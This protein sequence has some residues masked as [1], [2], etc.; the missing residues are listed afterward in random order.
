MNRYQEVRKRLTFES[1]GDS[2]TLFWI[3]CQHQEFG[4]LKC[5]SQ[6]N[7]AREFIENV[8]KGRFIADR[9]FSNYVIEL[10]TEVCEKSNKPTTLP[11]IIRTLKDLAFAMNNKIS[12][13]YLEL[14]NSGFI[15]DIM[16]PTSK[17]I[18]K[19]G[20]LV[21]YKTRTGR[22]TVGRYDEDKIKKYLDSMKK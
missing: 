13:N 1:V 20:K 12:F 19:K 14:L 7:K 17:Y 22:I 4:E 15:Q 8:D 9:N 10:W 18:C 2:K 11:H 21:L 16:D 6:N 5:L 3:K